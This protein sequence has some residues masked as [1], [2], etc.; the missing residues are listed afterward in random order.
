MTGPLRDVSYRSRASVPAVGIVLLLFVSIG[1]AASVGA[2][3]LDHAQMSSDGARAVLSLTV[4][5]DTLR[6]VHRG[7]ETLDVRRL[8]LRVSVDGAPLAEQPALPFFSEWGFRPGPTGPFNSAADARWSAGETASFAVADT[9]DPDLTAGSSV[10]VDIRYDGRPL[11]T[12]SVV[13][14]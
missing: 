2:V 12:L 3:A 7:G 6:F 1:L 5:D 8:D 11:A 14:R 9:N 10:T 4:S 13:V